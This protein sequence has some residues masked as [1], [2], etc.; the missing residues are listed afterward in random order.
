[1]NS[2][3]KDNNQ[4]NELEQ[5][6]IKWLEYVR[7]HGKLLDVFDKRDMNNEEIHIIPDRIEIYYIEGEI[8]DDVELT[9]FIRFQNNKIVGF[10][11]Y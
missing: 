11:T 9:V 3:I 7:K 2:E 5:E 8:F 6:D 4:Y 1:M 10:E